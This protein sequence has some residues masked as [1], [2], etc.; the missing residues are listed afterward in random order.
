MLSAYELSHRVQ[1]LRLHSWALQREG[2]KLP[3]N[4]DNL[5]GSEKI[6]A[7][8]KAIL[9]YDLKASGF[10][11]TLTYDEYS[12]LYRVE[13]PSVAKLVD[14]ACAHKVEFPATYFAPPRRE[15]DVVQLYLYDEGLWVLDQ[16]VDEL[17]K[18]LEIYRNLEATLKKMDVKTASN[19]D[20]NLEQEFMRNLRWNR[21][22]RMARTPL[23]IQR[24]HIRDIIAE[25]APDIEE[26]EGSTVRVE[27]NEGQSLEEAI[28]MALNAPAAG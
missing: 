28:F 25:Y 19:P 8:T 7:L 26:H 23:E 4:I 5:D 13:L 10:E 2:I 27:V 1:K 20:E 9:E 24:I 11:Y 12:Y 15:R 17:R 18:D 6:R 22:V 14:Q 16:Q 3:K 21:Q